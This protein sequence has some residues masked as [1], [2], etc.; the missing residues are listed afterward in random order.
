MRSGGGNETVPGH[1][2]ETTPDRSGCGPAPRA[3]ASVRQEAVARLA[4]LA[5]TT[6]AGRGTAT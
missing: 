1:D 4:T 6:R 5:K 2:R 3:P